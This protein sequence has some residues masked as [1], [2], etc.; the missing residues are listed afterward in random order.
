MAPKR[1]SIYASPALDRVLAER[2]KPD[3]EDEGFRSRSSMLS[4]IADRYAEIVR[5]STPDLSTPEWCAIF[6]ILN[7]CWMIDQPA[8]QATGL[9]HQIAD[10]AEMDGLGEKWQIDALDLARRVAALTFAEQI[11]IID[12]AERFWSLG[13]QDGEGYEAVVKRLVPH[14]K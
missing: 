3:S 6:D 12:T 4:A 10:A 9:A 13:V 11:A 7:G 1:Y 2:L 14:H 5:R 8:M